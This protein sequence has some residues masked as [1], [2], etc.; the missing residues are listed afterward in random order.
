L[1]EE[2]EARYEPIRHEFQAWVDSCRAE[3][4]RYA[5]VSAVND[6]CESPPQATSGIPG[7]ISEVEFAAQLGVV[8]ST[9]RRW[10]RQ[11]YGPQAVTIGRK[12]YYK[13]DAAQTFAAA[14]LDKA[15]AAAEPRRRG[16]P[17]R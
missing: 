11:R 10:R 13:Q 16:R 17:R 9:I 14:Q 4:S 15:E 7:Y 3:T 1:S 6:F 12:F 5:L 2:K 8:L